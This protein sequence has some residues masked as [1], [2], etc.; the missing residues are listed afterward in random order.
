MTTQAKVLTSRAARE[1]RLRESLVEASKAALV[2]A[3]RAGLRAL[4]ADWL[5]EASANPVF[6]WSID[7]W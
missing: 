2:N 5:E 6:R 3:S 1:L 4:P 7:E